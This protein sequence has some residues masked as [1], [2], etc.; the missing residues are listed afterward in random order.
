M[1]QI[2]GILSGFLLFIAGALILFQIKR[3]LSVPNLTTWFVI[4]LVSVV[5]AF[6]FHDI[7]HKNIYQSLIMFVSLITV[8]IIL[9]YSLNKGKFAKLIPFDLAMFIVA[10]AILLFWHYSSNDRLTNILIQIAIF[11]ANCATFVGLWKGYLKEYYLS[12]V[13]TV[14]AYIIALIGLVITFTGDWLPFLGPVLNGFL[15]N[16]IILILALRQYCF[17]KKLNP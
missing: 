11:A 12:W 15:G 13:F 6:T 4:V 14:A 10:I 8:I 9:F 2:F 5:N 1:S 17:R 16:G 7:V 3:N